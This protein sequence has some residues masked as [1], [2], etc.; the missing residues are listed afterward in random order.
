MLASREGTMRW[1]LSVLTIL[2]ALASGSAFAQ[3][4]SPAAKQKIT[5]TSVGDGF[6]FFPVYIAR[7]AGLFAEEGLDADWV[8]VGSGTKQAASVMGGSAEM[9]PLALMHAI[10]SQVEGADL[11]AFANVLNDW[12]MVVV[13]SNDAI[14]SAGIELAMPVDEKIKRLSGL[15]LGITS[16]GSS[17]DVSIRTMLMARDMVPDQVVKLQPLGD[18]TAILAAFDKKLVDGFV[19]A[20]PVP[21]IVEARGLGKIVINPLAREVPEQVGVPY[22]VMATSRATFEKKPEVI[23]ASA[24]AMTKALIFA[25]DKPAETLKIMQH[26]FPDVEPAI[27]ARIVTTYRAALPSSPVITREDVAKTVKFMNIGAAKPID[28][29]YDAVVLT[30]PAEAAAAALLKKK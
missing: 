29:K 16:P 7:G 6:Q 2:V 8:N 15:K 21:E 28:V 25:H 18:G 26:Y 1:N 27:L 23:R 13:L 5:I 30:G 3:T 20:S 14:K 4:A 19:F 10:K 24:R 17:T 9:T 11:V 22:S 12:S